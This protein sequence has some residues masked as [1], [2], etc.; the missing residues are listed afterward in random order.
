MPRVDFGPG[1]PWR[2]DSSPRRLQPRPTIGSA[3][4][5]TTSRRATRPRPGGALPPVADCCDGQMKK[6]IA[7]DVQ[8]VALA[9]TVTVT[10]AGVNTTPSSAYA[11]MTYV[12]G[13]LKVTAVD[14]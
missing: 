10:S 7:G 14:A 3:A 6:A 12:P 2:R 5:G 13:S 8:G 1:D 4:G 11:R 9:V